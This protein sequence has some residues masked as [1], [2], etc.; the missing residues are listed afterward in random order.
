V[1]FPKKRGFKSQFREGVCWLTI[2]MGSRS[3][4]WKNCRHRM[5]LHQDFFD[6][7]VGVLG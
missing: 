4:R 6:R 7:I 2:A 3:A 5:P 1:H